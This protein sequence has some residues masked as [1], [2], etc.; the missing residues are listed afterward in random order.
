MEPGRIQTALEAVLQYVATE[1]R[2][3]IKAFLARSE[4]DLHNRWQ[5]IRVT[6]ERN[7]VRTAAEWLSKHKAWVE[8]A[9]YERL[10][11]S[12]TDQLPPRDVDFTELKVLDDDAVGVIMVRAKLINQIM[13]Q[14]R[15]EI[16]SLEMR[17]DALK[18][19][20]ARLNPKA[21]GPG[22][23][24]DGFIG[25][26]NEMATPQDVQAL[27][28]ESYGEIG[29]KLLIELYQSLNQLLVSHGIL[30]KF[31]FHDVRSTHQQREVTTTELARMLESKFNRMQESLNNLP[32]KDWKPGTLRHMMDLPPPVQLNTVQQQSVDHIEA[33][34]L[35]LLRDERI[36]MR[37]RSELNRLILPTITLRL[38]SPDQFTAPDNPAR[39]FVRQ[40]ALLGF[41]DQEAPLA[42]FGKIQIVVDRIVSEQGQEL[43]GFRSGAQVLYTLARNEVDRRLAARDRVRKQASVAAARPV[44]VD[45][46]SDMAADQN[47]RE[48]VLV[49]LREQAAGLQLPQIVKNFTLLL[50][51]PWMMD[52]LSRFGPDSREWAETRAFADV[53][54][55]VLRPATGTDD[56]SRKR[57]LRRYA[58]MEARDRMQ[59]AGLPLDQ[60]RVMLEE[61]KQYLV[62]LDATPDRAPVPDSRDG[63]HSLEFLENL[64]APDSDMPPLSS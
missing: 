46:V 51:G 2:E 7:R 23:I 57:A 30:P 43:G 37:I 12:L 38:A 41:R 50:L 35:D 6:D 24:A 59:A 47:T 53:F 32:M 28:L 42:D 5:D 34:Y 14:A 52:Q 22:I 58:L 21:L 11:Q 27:L 20:G 63:E 40:L 61:L 19:G 49:E 15:Y 16:I 29:A 54:F 39:V 25:V 56:R 8:S 45:S 36:S 13:E 44:I 10:L 64:A 4:A 62:S 33:L 18:Q 17:L 3:R 1:L 48:T 31:T 26:L 9:M 60:A 55:D